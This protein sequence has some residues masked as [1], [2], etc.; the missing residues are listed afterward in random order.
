MSNGNE[1][2]VVDDIARSTFSDS[3]SKQILSKELQHCSH[4]NGITGTSLSPFPKVTKSKYWSAGDQSND[5]VFRDERFNQALAPS[6]SHRQVKGTKITKAK[7][8][9]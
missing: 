9:P 7:V 1:I 6:Y 8:T 3:D 5:R 4:T 2:G